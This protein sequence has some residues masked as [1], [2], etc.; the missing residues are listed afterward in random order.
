MA[1]P[2]T[3]TLRRPPEG[4]AAWHGRASAWW[5]AQESRA[6]ALGVAC[7]ALK[8]ACYALYPALVVLLACD[9][10]GGAGPEAFRRALLLPALG[11]T[12]VS[13]M[14]VQ[15]AEPRPYEACAIRQLIPKD[16]RGK[17]FPSRHVYSIAV[18]GGCWLYR[19]APV[20]A[21]ILAA[22]L[23]MAYARVV[24]GLHYPRDVACGYV[25]GMAFA[26]P[27]WV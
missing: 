3:D 5:Q 13:V 12:V 6:R 24:G 25:L 10:L 11:F 2:I 26:A 8:Y 1:S 23:V 18:I 21:L 15:I 7:T 9:W 17:S 14:R 16:T 20:G 27:L 22:A 4:Y 19:C